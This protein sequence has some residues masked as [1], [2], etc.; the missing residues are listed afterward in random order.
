MKFSLTID[1]DNDAFQG[2]D[3]DPAAELARILRTLASRIERAEEVPG[4]WAIRDYNGN[5]V[6]TAETD[7]R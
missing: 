1:M 7:E 4:T 6:G 2:L 3:A 5:T